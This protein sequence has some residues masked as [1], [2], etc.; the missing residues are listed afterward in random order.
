MWRPLSNFP[1]AGRTID[2]PE[3]VTL[4]VGVFPSRRGSSREHGLRVSRIPPPDAVIAEFHTMDEKGS[5]VN[6]VAHLVND[7]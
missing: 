6:L 3:P 2:A 1:V 4:P 5:D 7:T